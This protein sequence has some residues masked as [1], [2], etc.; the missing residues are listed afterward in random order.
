MMVNMNNFVGIPQTLTRREVLIGTGAVLAAAGTPSVFAMSDDHHHGQHG[1]HQ[2]LVESTLHCIRDGEACL[3]HCLRLFKEGDT[4]VADCAASVTEM[5]AMCTAMQKMASHDSKYAGKLASV[6]LKV[7]RDCEKQCNKH[8]K[9]Y[10]ACA[11]CAR[12]W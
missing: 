7:C 2:Q 1:K 12:S 11:A 3:D 10:E 9:K 6:C 5:L 8:A 4:S